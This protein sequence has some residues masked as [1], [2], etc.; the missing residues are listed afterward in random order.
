MYATHKLHCGTQVVCKACHV[1]AQTQ[2]HF[3]HCPTVLFVHVDVLTLRYGTAL[4]AAG[5]QLLYDQ[6][7]ANQTRNFQA[8]CGRCAACLLEAN[9]TCV[10]A[11]V[12]I[13]T[14]IPVRWH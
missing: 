10:A 7:E 4:A 11:N 9:I 1:T 5:S 8:S 12:L 6:A 2:K 14:T 3:A 13:A